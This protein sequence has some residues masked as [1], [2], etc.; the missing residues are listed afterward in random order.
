MPAV[1]EL[2]LI[3]F[4]GLVSWAAAL[5]LSVMSVRIHFLSS[6]EGA[7]RGCLLRIIHINT[8]QVCSPV[9]RVF[10]PEIRRKTLAP[11]PTPLLDLLLQLYSAEAGSTT[12]T[13]D[14]KEREGGASKDYD[15]GLSLTC[16]DGVRHVSRHILFFILDRLPVQIDSQRVSWRGFHI[17]RHS[18]LESTGHDRLRSRA[19]DSEVKAR[20]RHI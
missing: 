19:G 17:P 8:T 9:R 11:T 5:A 15:I 2:G 4:T 10:D 3:I 1:S 14:H 13:P 18:R 12:G 16:L 20:R 6:R 7:K